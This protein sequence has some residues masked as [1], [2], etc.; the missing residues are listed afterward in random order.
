[1]KAE[2]LLVIEKV[3]LANLKRDNMRATLG[4]PIQEIKK[5]LSTSQFRDNNQKYEDTERQMSIKQI[6]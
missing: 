6:F 4:K 5:M 2:K 1:M 3:K